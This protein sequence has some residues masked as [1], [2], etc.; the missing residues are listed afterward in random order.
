MSDGSGVNTIH[1]LGCR[2]LII[3][4]VNIVLEGKGIIFSMDM[5]FPFTAVIEFIAGN[6]S[7][8]IIRPRNVLAEFLDEKTGQRLTKL[9][10]EY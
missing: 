4:N 2:R 6:M 10:D 9:I 8:D 5:A 7:H 1:R 3:Y